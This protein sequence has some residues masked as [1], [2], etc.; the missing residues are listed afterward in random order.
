MVHLFL[1]FAGLASAD[2]RTHD[3]VVELLS[4]I[5]TS[6]TAAEW[7]AVGPAAASELL[8]LATDP[9]A[10]PTVRANAI[11]AL[12]HFPT[13]EARALLVATLADRGA[14]SLSRRKAALG[15]ALGWG[16]AS[17]PALES[18][19][20]DPDEQVRGAVARALSNIDDPAAQGVL[21]AR[22]KV[23]SAA[24]VQKLIAAGVKP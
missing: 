6:P 19:F 22:A 5:E 17:V 1:L 4:G 16:A 21:A 9:A 10:L 12:G 13:V 14:P 24:S 18:V 15:L 3:R 2:E 23:E 20:A 8:Q 11:F 7:Q